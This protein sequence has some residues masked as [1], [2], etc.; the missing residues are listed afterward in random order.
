MKDN[1]ITLLGAICGDIIGSTLEFYPTKRMDFEL[2]PEGSRF[3]DDTVMTCAV[4]EWTMHQNQDLARTL[5]TWGLRY[6]DI[7]YGP[8]FLNWLISRDLTPTNSAGNGTAM[9][10]SSIGWI[11]ATL[12]QCN[13]LAKQTA[14]VSHS[15]KE[16]IKGAQAIASSIFLARNGAT[17]EEIAMH[18]YKN[19]KGYDI[20]RESHLI[21]AYYQFNPTC[22]GSVP[23][24]IIAF[25]E[26]ED[27][28]SAIR[29]AI[30][31]GGD[32][33][34]MAAIAG[35]IA[36]AFYK[37]IPD[38]ITDK[39]LSLLTPDVRKIVDDFSAFIDSKV[40]EI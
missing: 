30:S 18:I 4:A 32:A 7:G 34:T 8:M 17:K 14:I 6:S 33:D 40:G 16:A 27:Y 26:S 31:L 29:I 25:L 23:E 13:E 9:R 12:E 36:S 10:V 1:R 39:C 35:S 20:L 19:Y 24:S 15:H 11:A 22:Q 21:R 5:Q 28:E 3:T 2:I 37:E 38:T